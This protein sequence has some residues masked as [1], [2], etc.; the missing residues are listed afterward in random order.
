VAWLVSFVIAKS[1]FY[2]NLAFSGVL[3][4]LKESPSVVEPEPWL[5][6]G[7]LIA[8]LQ[9]FSNNFFDMDKIISYLKKYPI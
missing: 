7:G 5:F 8:D 6:R 2:T 1:V 4:S 3:K 9:V